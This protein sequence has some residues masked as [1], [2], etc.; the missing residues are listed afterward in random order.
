[1]YQ[2]DVQVILDGLAAELGAPVSLDD[3]DLRLLGHTTHNVVD[4]VRSFVIMHRY[5]PTGVREW[6]E[7]WG[8]RQA[9]GPVRTP[10]DT[11]I[12]A[13]ERWCVPVRYRERLLAYIWVLD[14]GTIAEGDLGPAIEAA[15]HI[16]ALIYRRRLSAQVDADLLRLL[17][18]PN[19]ENESAAAEA[20]ALGTFA[21]KG[22]VAVVVLA[23]LGGDPDEATLSDLE[24][25]VQRAA[26]Q[27]TANRA[28]AGT[29]SGFGVVLVALRDRDDLV[30]ARR[31]AEK[32]RVLAANI[33]RDLETVAAVGG[34]TELE[35][36]SQ[37]YAQARR[38]LRLVRAVP[39]LG[40][41]ATWDSLGVFRVLALL[42]IRDVEGSVIDP[43]VRELLSDDGL[44]ETAEIF[45]DTAGNIQQTAA[46]LYIHR[47]TLYQRLD[48]ID[49]LYAL[50]LRNSGDHRLITHLG[51]KQARVMRGDGP[52]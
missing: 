10:A 51:L 20:R 48:R 37:S 25:A 41:V 11:A 28:L 36:A 26:E 7:Q 32:T 29:L 15:N 52:L 8:I 49:A 35:S 42:P 2:G 22:P 17:L 6:F 30:V 5:L 34:A 1:V 16:G 21:P 44:A 19:P 4:D 12:G 33:N 31:L 13:Y 38:V 45:L 46:R 9:H 27:P 14:A 18:V 23:A 47:T 39:D 50:D 24:L 40:P 3:L 43:R